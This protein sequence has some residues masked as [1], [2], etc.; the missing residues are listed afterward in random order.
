MAGSIVAEH[1][2]SVKQAPKN[3]VKATPFTDGELFSAGRN[4]YMNGKRLVSCVSDAE[5]K[6]WLHQ[7]AVCADAYWGHMMAEAPSPADDA[8]W[9]RKG[10]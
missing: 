6:G 2:P 7:E 10:C 1:Q 8:E 3:L 9:I 5:A 4:A